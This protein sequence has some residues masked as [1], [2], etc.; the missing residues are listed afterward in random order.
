MPSRSGR[1]PG[2]RPDQTRGTRGRTPRVAAPAPDR[3][4]VRRPGARALAIGVGLVLAAGIGAAIVW[5]GSTSP[6]GPATS[7][8]LPVAD[9]VGTTTCRA[10]HESE[11]RAWDTS[12]HAAAMAEATATTVLGRFDDTTFTKDGVT[13]T[14]FKRDDRFFVRTD[15]ADGQLADF[16]IAYTFGVAPLQQYLIRFPD[17]RIQ[18][19]G[20]AWDSR[21]QAEGGQR[22]FHLYPDESIPHDDPLHWTGLQQNWNF[23]CADCHSTNLRKGYDS[24]ARTFHTTWSEISV[25]CE[26]CHGPGSRHVDL[27]RAGRLT[28]GDTG[29]TARLDERAGVTWRFD[30]TAGLPV[31]STPRTTTREIDTC[32]RC[33]SRRAQLTDAW[34]A[35]QPFEDG[36][37]PS[38]LEAPLYYPDGQQRDEVYTIGS[39]TQSRMHAAGVTCS[40]C[41]DP[42]AGRLRV[43]GNGT[44]VQCHQASTYDSPAHHFHTP[45]TAAAAC[46]SCHMP[47]TT[48]MVVDP[49]HDHSFRVPRPDRTVTIGVPNPCSTCHVAEGAAWAARQIAQRRGHAPQGFQ[50]FAE[51]FAAADRGA[52][53]AAD[54]GR[55]AADPSQSTIARASAIARLAA[56]GAPPFLPIDSLIADDNPMIRRTAIEVIRSADPATRVRLAAPRLS[57]PVRTVRSEAARTLAD[58]ADRG[59]PPTWQPAF[60]H[61]FDELVDEY[62]F[63]GDRP[64]AQAGLGSLWLSRGRMAES[65]AALRE[66]LRLDPRFGPAYVN[67]AE[68]HRLRGEEGTAERTLREAIVVLPRDGALHHALGLSLVRQKRVTEAIT[69]LRLAVDLAPESSRYAYVLGVALNDTGHPAE[70]LAML[71]AA[72][73]RHPA[74]V[75]L[76]YLL[77]LYSAR[78]GQAA[79]AQRYTDLLEQL[80]P[81]HPAIRDLRAR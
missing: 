15:G 43:P 11:A 49:R 58:L 77:A 48:Y 78:S 69:E 50:M 70:A 47:T 3:T 41:H 23:M 33:H 27:A 44:C 66:A 38:T 21:A 22:W 54:L 40:D 9:F 67:L 62:R 46:T 65:E 52:P 18:A 2:A 37:R 71:R 81:G 19:L 16:E 26:S 31:R 12:Q 1:Q 39:F 32:A 25:G 34:H 63:N 64:E 4:E 29:L 8:S 36:F 24:T 56:V 13:S 75:D 53:A 76:V 17:G 60:A 45:G 14:F 72:H 61:A 35:G 7:V 5:R 68:V 20:I 42:H 55:I 6:P 79:D 57:D 73:D 80:D 10:C 59:L 51:V 28:A 30:T 74:D